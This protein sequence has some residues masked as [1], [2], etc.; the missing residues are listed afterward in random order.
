MS[1]HRWVLGCGTLSFLV[2][3]GITWLSRS[4]VYGQG[5][6][7]RPLLLFV[8]LSTVAFVLYF[9]TLRMLLRGSHDRHNLWLL[10]GFAIIFRVTLLFSHPIQEDDFYR[11]LWDGKVVASG[12]NPYRVAPLTV[13]NQ[14]TGHAELQAYSRIPV[15]DDAFALILSRVN[16]PAVPTIY[17]PLAQAVFGLVALVAPGSLVALRLVFLGCDLGICGL[18]IA[19]LKRLGISPLLVIVYA[20]SPL[21]MKESI[22]SAHYDAVPT[23]FLVLA[24][25]SS[26]KEKV[27]L[28]YTSLALAVL[29]KVY[30]LLVVPFFLWRT[31]TTQGR[32]ASLVG[33]GVLCIGIVLGYVPFLDA[34]A[35]LWQG[36]LTFAERWETNSLL[37]PLLRA[38][39]GERWIAN[40]IVAVVLG[41]TVLF[42]LFRCDLREERSFVWANFCILGVL[43]LL[44]PVGNPWYFLWIMPFLCVFPLFS[45]LLLSGLLSLYYLSFYFI[46]RD[47]AET[48]R[49]VIWLEYIPFYVILIWE[50]MSQRHDESPPLAQ[51]SVCS[52]V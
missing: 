22:N 38:L 26:L 42:L 23:F 2:Y 29:G 33:I 44:S 1:V 12:L 9:L 30:P 46:Y 16:H 11:Y 43:F 45:W 18:I 27:L 14:E 41:G 5:H 50:W 17:P 39:V 37:F 32:S 31:W 21:V 36:T 35:F 52:V 20:W 3:A 40:T 6:L 15:E 48:F 10:L 19:L 51:P 7:Q 28:T 47:A 34:G 8:A 24:L 4:F 49:W 13:R 25:W